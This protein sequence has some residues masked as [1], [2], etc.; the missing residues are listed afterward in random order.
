MRIGGQGGDRRAGRDPRALGRDAQR[1][2]RLGADERQLE[3]AVQVEHQLEPGARGRARIRRR[4]ARIDRAGLAVDGDDGRPSRPRVCS[5]RTRSGEALASRSRTRPPGGAVSVK[6]R[7]IGVGAQSRRVGAGE[8]D[9]RVEIDGGRGGLVDD[10]RAEQA[11]A[12]L[13]GRRAGP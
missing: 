10:D 8:R 3:G 5:G 11:A 9:H 13:I 4:A 1:R 2:P 6:R 12:K 7:G